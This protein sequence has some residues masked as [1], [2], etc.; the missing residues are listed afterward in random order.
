MKAIDALNKMC[1]TSKRE[2]DE[3]IYTISDQR[4]PNYNGKKISVKL[5]YGKTIVEWKNN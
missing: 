4:Y 1:H 5:E 2:W 3:T